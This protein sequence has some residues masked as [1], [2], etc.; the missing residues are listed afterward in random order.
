[1]FIPDTELL[2]EV[3]VAGASLSRTDAGQWVLV[4]P[5]G[6][7]LND[8]AKI[9]GWI[10]RRLQISQTI[11]QNRQR[12]PRPSAFGMDFDASSMPPLDYTVDRDGNHIPDVETP[13]RER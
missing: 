11:V 1:V 10:F 13:A 3:K 2:P 12:P 4:L 6:E 9:L 5:R 7:V 8:P